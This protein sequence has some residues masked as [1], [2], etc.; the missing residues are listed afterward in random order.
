MVV[1]GAVLVGAIIIGAVAAIGY[2]LNVARTAPALATLH[3]ILSG[4]SSQVFASDGTRLGFIQS[5]QLRT[6]VG[7]NEIP[8]TLKNATVAIEDQRFYKHDGVD[9]T[10]I[11]RAA[12]KDITHGAALQGG[13]TITMQLMR[14]IYLGG[15]QHTLRQKI[16]EAKLALD[17]EKTH[18]K[19]SILTSYLNSVPYG[20][21]GG[22]TAIGVQAAARIFFNKPVYQLNVAQAALLAGLPQA[23]SQYNPFRN[24]SAAKA[25]RNEVL[26]KMAELHYIS[27]AQASAA[28]RTSLGVKHGTFYSQRREDFFFEYVREQLVH[29][30]GAKTVAQGG[31]K[32]YTTINLNMQRQAR[33]AI[34]EVLNQPE[35]P[36]AAI[37][38]LNPANGNIEAMAESESYEKSQYNLA[39]DGHRQ[40][41][42]TFKAIDLADAL[43]RGIDPNTTFYNSHELQAGWLQNVRRQLGRQHQPG[44]GDPQIRQHGL[45]P[46][47]GRPRL[48]N[49][50]ADGLQDGRHDAP[51]ELPRGSARRADARRDAARNGDRVRDARRRRLAQHADRDHEGRLPGRQGRWQLGQAASREGPQRSRHRGRDG[52]PPPERAR[53][54]RGQIGDQ[55]PDG[56]QDGHHQRTGRRVARRLHAEL[57]DRRMDGLSHQACIDDERPRRV[58]AGW[59]PA[60]RHLA[61]IHVRGHRR[62]ALRS[63]PAVQ[64]SDLLPALLRQIRDDRPVAGRRRIRTRKRTHCQEEAWSRRWP[65]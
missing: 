54:H 13:S 12:V 41:G 36:A 6:P 21:V 64:R 33:K 28:E 26:R 37:V 18:D 1:G 27:V 17:Y 20:T 15:D 35:D 7:S 14:N 38:T 40:P 11:F 52:D 34:A 51:L 43:T 50:H 5:D 59:S 65:R 57:L 62:K 8:A 46:A 2:V 29:R 32:V 19:R 24:P 42:S 31:L 48:G 9:L 22:Q 39:A 55:L 60:G 30:Y 45:R 4:G 10:G 63:V 25:R 49:D 23:P 61:R 56:R 58:T 16:I 3:P 44:P 47:G 53:R